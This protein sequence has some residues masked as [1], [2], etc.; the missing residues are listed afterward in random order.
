MFKLMRANKAQA[1]SGAPKEGI[2]Y[3]ALEHQIDERIKHRDVFNEQIK[4]FGIDQ[5]KH[6]IQ[7]KESQVKNKEIWF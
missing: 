3:E 5:E 7:I 2:E 4:Q 1:V 6:K